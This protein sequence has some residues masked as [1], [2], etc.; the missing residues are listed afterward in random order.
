MLK[1][2]DVKAIGELIR[3]EGSRVLQQHS[4]KSQ[5]A[6]GATKVTSAKK[7]GSLRLSQRKK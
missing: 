1:K 3:R 5:S 2:K 4:G 6:K 7:V